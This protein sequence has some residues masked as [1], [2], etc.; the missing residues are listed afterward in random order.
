MVS[1][2]PKRRPALR[3]ESKIFETS[4]GVLDA[5]AHLLEKDLYD[6]TER[7]VCEYWLDIVEKSGIRA[8]NSEIR[9]AILD[10]GLFMCRD[11]HSGFMLMDLHVKSFLATGDLIDEKTSKVSSDCVCNGVAGNCQCD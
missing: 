4:T 1:S 7:E 6:M 5:V 8:A 10:S 3:F 2:K 9:E 11:F